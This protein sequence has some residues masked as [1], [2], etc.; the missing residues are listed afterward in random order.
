MITY[1]VYLS[2]IEPTVFTFEG[3]DEEIGSLEISDNIVTVPL[4]DSNQNVKCIVKANLLKSAGDLELLD[5]GLLNGSYEEEALKYVWDVWNKDDAFVSWE[6]TYEEEKDDEGEL[7]SE[8]Y[9]SSITI[10]YCNPSDTY[11]PNPYWLATYVEAANY[12]MSTTPTYPF[13]V[14][15]RIDPTIKFGEL[16]D[17]FSYFVND[18]KKYKDE[19]GNYDFDILV[20]GVEKNIFGDYNSVLNQINR[21][22]D[23]FGENSVKIKQNQTYS[24]TVVINESEEDDDYKTPLRKTITG[25]DEQI[26]N[27]IENL[28]EIYGEDNVEILG[29][30]KDI[31]F[32]VWNKSVSQDLQ[33][34]IE[35]QPNVLPGEYIQ[36]R[37]EM[38]VNSSIKEGMIATVPF[39]TP[40]FTGGKLLSKQKSKSR[41]DGIEKI[42]YSAE[43]FGNI[44]TGILPTDNYD[45]EI[46]K[47]GYFIK[48]EDLFGEHQKFGESSSDESEPSSSND[49]SELINLINK[50]RIENGLDPLFINDN[51]NNSSSSHANDMA[52]NNYVGHIDSEELDIFDRI[53]N[54]GYFNDFQV[55]GSITVDA[56]DSGGNYIGEILIDGQ[57]EDFIE[58]VKYYQEEYGD[59]AVTSELIY[60]DYNIYES[61]QRYNK[62]VTYNPE[63]QKDVIHI[64][65]NN[66]SFNKFIEDNDENLLRTDISEIGASFKLDS[67]NNRYTV[68]QFGLR[69]DG[70]Q[71]NYNSY[72]RLTPFNF[73]GSLSNKMAISYENDLT[74][75][76]ANNF[77]KI[78]DMKR[79]ECQVKE[80]DYDNDTAIVEVPINSSDI[81]L[82][83]KEIS[84]PI[85][86][87]CTGDPTIEGGAQAF[88][89]NDIAIVEQSKESEDADDW[90]DA[91]IV[92]IKDDLKECYAFNEIVVQCATGYIGVYDLEKKEWKEV[93]DNGNWIQTPC[94]FSQIRDYLSRLPSKVTMIDDYLNEENISFGLTFNEKTQTWKDVGEYIQ[95]DFYSCSEFDDCEPKGAH[96]IRNYTYDNQSGTFIEYCE[97][98]GKD[99]E[100]LKSSLEEYSI[101]DDPENKNIYVDFPIG[102]LNSPAGKYYNND[103]FSIIFSSYFFEN[104]T[105]SGVTDFRIQ[106]YDLTSK[107]LNNEKTFYNYEFNEAEDGLDNLIQMRYNHN[108]YCFDTK[109]SNSTM[110]TGNMAIM[111]LWDYLNFHQGYSITSNFI[112][113]QS[114]DILDGA[115]FKAS[116]SERITKIEE[117][118]SQEALSYALEEDII[119]F[120][121][122]KDYLG[123]PIMSNFFY[124]YIADKTGE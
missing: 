19:D 15:S 38:Q 60:G 31:N 124:I 54:F 65:S 22:K 16:P 61:I 9:Y 118:I 108:G 14:S 109:I 62:I 18:F 2:S 84:L 68:I 88:D 74:I 92:G 85:F 89:E 79:F 94:H 39:Q 99:S 96:F 51:L 10:N 87:H 13:I 101:V 32:P 82:G 3:S 119:W 26:D 97:N 8:T 104:G 115:K 52:S 28:K 49:A 93:L 6:R 95:T 116:E 70:V 105:Y 4:T 71:N 21:Y 67:D 36:L 55:N 63:T 114:D 98:N 112:I 25:N 40:L 47:W 24:L 76:F 73:K 111:P 30:K 66:E 81:S 69:E 83:T 23:L 57:F 91:Y 64:P 77:E 113:K 29:D 46:G 44:Y 121:L 78:F 48:N 56:S 107:I 110:A 33:I 80:V 7:I 45:Y 17:S 100:I 41:Q 43:I 37:W 75:D 5:T 117:F 27:E 50:Y 42:L 103:D 72:Y 120:D 35:N 102:N 106:N 34:H 122:T 58:S 90:D 1:N 53:F 20:E 123:N 59:E 11:T 12:A 86:Y